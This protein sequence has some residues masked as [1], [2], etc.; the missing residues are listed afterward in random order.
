MSHKKAKLQV[1]L[2][3]NEQ[4]WNEFEEEYAWLRTCILQQAASRSHHPAVQAALQGMDL[5]LQKRK[6]DFKLQQKFQSL[7]YHDDK[8]SMGNK[9]QEDD[10][11]LIVEKEQEA[12][13]SSS[14]LSQTHRSE[15]PT[16]H[17]E[18]DWLNV[19]RNEEEGF[20][21]A[22]QDNP[23]SNSSCACSNTSRSSDTPSSS[24]GT[25]YL[26]PYVLE[27]MT[28]HY[29]AKAR[30]PRAAI[31]MALHTALRSPFLNFQ[32]LNTPTTVTT[33]NHNS[34]FAPPVRPLND[35]QFLPTGWKDDDNDDEPTTCLRYR[36]NKM[37]SV[38]LQVLLPPPNLPDDDKNHRIV[39]VSLRPSSEEEPTT[40]LTFPLSQHFNLESFQKAQKDTTAV[41]P[42]LH[43]KGL[44]QLLDRF[45]TTFD[46]GCALVDPQSSNVTTNNPTTTTLPSYPQQRYPN[47][48]NNTPYNPPPPRIETSFPFPSHH[49]GD[50]EGDLLPRGVGSLD[51][52]QA[53]N[54]MGPGHPAF[55]GG[56]RLDHLGPSS[57]FGMRPRFDPF[58]PPGGPTDPNIH[59]PGG[60][61]DPNPDHLR[62]TNYLGNNNNN[63]NNRFM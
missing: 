13:T 56:G 31:L 59:P 49:R 43:Y 39:Q 21:N 50:F 10:D 23:S 40:T 6:R 54:L 37:G 5:D 47:N 53:G 29:Q 2:P 11:I 32:C 57:G 33:T 27:T 42:A 51:P 25:N 20:D 36:N 34:S 52:G 3:R 8:N 30:S 41:P 12:P 4:E 19:T 14:S 44:A 48:I 15:N 26:A 22:K 35:T 38:L 28:N 46:L 61:G 7:K 1:L 45:C 63:N 17:S 55:Q 16:T 62:P 60:T 58:G 9:L 24:L 18:D